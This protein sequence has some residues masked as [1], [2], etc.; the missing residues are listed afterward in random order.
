[1]GNRCPWTR[2][3]I[4]PHRGLQTIRLIANRSVNRIRFEFGGTV[5]QL[6]KSVLVT[7]LVKTNQKVKQME[8]WDSCINQVFSGK[9]KVRKAIS[10]VPGLE[11]GGYLKNAPDSHLILKHEAP[12]EQSHSESW[13]D[14]GIE[15]LQWVY[16]LQ[17]AKATQ[18]PRQAWPAERW[19]T[20]VHYGY[21]LLE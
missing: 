3:N 19:K 6:R 11:H 7:A 8:S 17:I 21:L 5:N 20:E 1:M 18:R 16:M 13:I 2:G 4:G 9:V 14:R 10:P 12:T 15:L